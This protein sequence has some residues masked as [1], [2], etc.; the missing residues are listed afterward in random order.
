MHGWVGAEWQAGVCL[1]HASYHRMAASCLDYDAACPVCMALARLAGI[2]PR[3]AAAVPRPP[4]TVY[5]MED[6]RLKMP[7]RRPR[8][9]M[10][11]GSYGGHGSTTW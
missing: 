1:A 7:D 3:E 8:V 5:R 9:A 10:A 11:T 2:R 4:D 6:T